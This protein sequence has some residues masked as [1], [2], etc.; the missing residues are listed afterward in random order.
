MAQIRPS[1]SGSGKAPAS[2]FVMRPFSI[3]AVIP[4][5]GLAWQLGSQTV[6]IERVSV[7]AE[8]SRIQGNANEQVLLKIA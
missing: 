4:Q 6:L 8:S 5:R 1:Y 2:S 7:T 3:C